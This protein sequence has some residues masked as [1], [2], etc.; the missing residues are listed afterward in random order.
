MTGG[1]LP[2]HSS[3]RNLNLACRITLGKM[4]PR[5]LPADDMGGAQMRI[6]RLILE[7][8]CVPQTC[9]PGKSMG[10]PIR[11]P[12]LSKGI[13]QAIQS[14]RYTGE[15]VDHPLWEELSRKHKRRV[16][17]SRK[18]FYEQ[19][20]KC[21]KFIACTLCVKQAAN[22]VHSIHDSAGRLHA[23]SSVIA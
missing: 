15:T 13:T 4:S 5:G 14:P 18:L 19:S 20:D 6:K 8:K 3:F 12:D 9:L 17:L 7:I 16:M 23:S 2:T 21:G 22:H 1:S 11:D 10:S